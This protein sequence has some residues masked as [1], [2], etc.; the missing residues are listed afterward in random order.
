MAPF[1]EPLLLEPLL[2]PCCWNHCQS[3]CHLRSN[4]CRGA[5]VMLAIEAIIGAVVLGTIVEAVV[6]RAIVSQSQFCWSYHGAVFGAIVV[7]GAIVAEEPSLEQL[8]LKPLLQ[9]D[10]WSCCHWHHSWSHCRSHSCW[11]HCQSDLF[12][13]ELLWSHRWSHCCWR[14]NFCR[15]AIVRA[16]IARAIVR[17][18]PLSERGHHWT[19]C[20]W[21]HHWSHC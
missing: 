21:H 19:C 2:E 14:S 9:G 18:R 20:H 3:H 10:R 12:L 15:G 13:L 16:I 1:L 5:I 4:C 17:A 11:S 7:R 6:I 8:L